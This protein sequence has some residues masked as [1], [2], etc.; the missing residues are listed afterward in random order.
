M[1]KVIVRK[2]AVPVYIAAAVWAIYALAF[3]LYKVGHFVIAAAVAVAAFFLSRCFFK[4]VKEEVEVEPEPV[5]TG[6]EALDS[7]IAQGQLALKEM[8][9]LDENIEDEVISGQ[10]RRLEELS[11]KIFDQVR[12]KPE[13]LPQIRKFMDYYLPTTLKLLNAYDRMG[14]QGLSGGNI[15]GTMERVE[16]IMGTIVTAF[17]RQLD[18][19]FGAEALDISTDI[20]VL[21]N[22]MAREGLSEDPVHRAAQ[23]KTQN[24]KEEP[25]DGGIQLEL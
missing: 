11:G 5:R 18:A 10:I 8:R 17:E 22:M 15:G 6:N 13:K 7:M 4:D 2:S 1:K 16:S 14:T 24:D 3:P 23:Q 12:Q 19:L 25:S 21:E 20:T 9:R